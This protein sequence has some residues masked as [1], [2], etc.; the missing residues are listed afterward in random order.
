MGG[1]THRVVDAGA[2][3]PNWSALTGWSGAGRRGWLFLRGWHGERGR[4][5]MQPHPSIRLSHP[6]SPAQ[7]FPSSLRSGGA[8]R[9]GR[10]G[11][12]AAHRLP[13]F[14]QVLLGPG[15][16][17]TAVGGHQTRAGAG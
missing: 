1:E 8:W 5:G 9:A 2:A 7:L 16:G 13:L 15:T 14:R 17:G 4:G 12:E 10:P 6:P 3:L 11:R